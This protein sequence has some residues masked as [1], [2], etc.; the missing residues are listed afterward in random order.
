MTVLSFREATEVTFERQRADNLHLRAQVDALKADLAMMGGRLRAEATECA[1][2]EGENELLQG[3]N[4]RLEAEL[5]QLREMY[6]DRDSDLAYE[7]ERGNKEEQDCQH[8]RE[9]AETAEAALEDVVMEPSRYPDLSARLQNVVDHMVSIARVALA[10][11]PPAAQSHPIDASG[12]CSKLG[13]CTCDGDSD[14]DDHA[15]LNDTE[16]VYHIQRRDHTLRET[17]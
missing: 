8:W 4:V 1:Y 17:K 7:F 6:A 5:A 15:M 12:P 3:K 11:R 9:R 2:L 16:W 14:E 13:G 10:S